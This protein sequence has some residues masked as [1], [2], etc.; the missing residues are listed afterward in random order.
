MLIPLGAVIAPRV[1]SYFSQPIKT[2]S[3]KAKIVLSNKLFFFMF[4]NI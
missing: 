2:R 1:Y 4:L 3:V